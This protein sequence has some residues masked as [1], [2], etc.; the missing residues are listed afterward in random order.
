MRMRHDMLGC[1]QQLRKAQGDFHHAVE[2]VMEHWRDRQA[3]IFEQQSLADWSRVVDALSKELTECAE[4]ANQASRR[5]QD[6]QH[7]GS[8]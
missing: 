8:L 7:G 3:E 1:A 5:L 6:P 2:E 4:W